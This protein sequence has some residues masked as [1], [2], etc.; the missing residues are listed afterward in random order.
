MDYSEALKLL[1]NGKIDDCIKYFKENKFNL[2]YGYALMLSGDLDSAQRIF[3]SIDSRRADWALKI[4]P[5]MQGRISDKPTYF[6]IR[7]FLEIDLTLLFK[8]GQKEYVQYILGGADIFQN[9]NR[10]SYKFIG[11]ALLKNG[12]TESAKMFLD[13]SLSDFYRDPE[14]HYLF[15]EYYLM[16]NDYVNAKRAVE[17]CLK[18]NPDYF[19]AKQ[20]EQKLI[21]YINK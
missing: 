2:E 15:V 16:N 14:L 9:I 7:S 1:E 5:L 4:I 11:R 6:Q 3:S 13:K 18:V 17:N 21:H 20:T 10:E 19:P 8:A 12:Y